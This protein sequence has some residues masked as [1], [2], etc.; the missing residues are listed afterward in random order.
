MSMRAVVR[1]G[2][3]LTGLWALVSACTLA[4]PTT[5][6]ME[7]E[8]DDDDAKPKSA[9]AAVTSAPGGGGCSGKFAKPDVSKLTKCGAGK[10]HCYDKTK[11][12]A[13]AAAGLNP[14]PNAAEVCVPDEI[15]TA[16][17]GALKTCNSIIGKGACLQVTEM[18]VPP[19]FKSQLNM[20]TQDTCEAGMKCTPCVNPMKNNE[21]NPL[22]GPQVG[23]SETACTGGAATGAAATA[24]APSGPQELC[25]TTNGKSNGTCLP[26]TAIPAANKGDVVADTCS[27][28]KMCVPTALATGAPVKCTAGPFG[29]G[30]AGVCMDQCFNSMLGIAGFVFGNEGCGETE[31][32]VPCSLG[33]DKGLPGCN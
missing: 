18:L 22:C 13:E 21:A 16:G 24:A 26:E 11:M 31:T 32:C 6:K 3:I 12:P 14:C 4:S 2:V 15:L 9:E 8:G 25:C 33:K 29:M 19:E 17:G 30:G 27:A 23:V 20:L 28:G 5:I 1:T 7:P 10:S